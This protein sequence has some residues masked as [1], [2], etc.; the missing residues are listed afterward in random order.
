MCTSRECH[1]SPASRDLVGGTTAAPGV[2]GAGQSRSSRRLEHRFLA[3]A[4]DDEIVI[5]L[6]TSFAAPGSP[7]GSA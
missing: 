2:L 3:G 6:N 7:R 1:A 5:E 4:R